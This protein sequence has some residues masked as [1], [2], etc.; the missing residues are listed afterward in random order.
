VRVFDAGGDKPLPGLSRLE[1]PN[2]A[3]GVRG[4]RALRENPSILEAQLESIA[5]AAAYTDADVWVMAPMVSEPE[6]AQ[7]FAHMVAA[8][9]LRT[10]GVMIEVPAAALLAREILSTVD[11]ASIGTNDLTAV[12]ARGRPSARGDGPLAGPVAPAVLRLVSEVGRAAGALGKPLGVC[13]EA[14][15]DPRLACV[16]VGLGVTSLSMAPAA[17]ACV[18]EELALHTLDECRRMAEEALGI[19]LPRIDPMRQTQV[20][21]AGGGPAGLMLGL[22]L[23]RQGIE[24]IVLEK[25]ADF[26][27]DFRGDTV[28]S[29]TLNILDEIGLT[30]VVSKLPGRRRHS[31]A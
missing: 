25:H 26:L 2:P 18:R 15:G 6:E 12:H 30:D 3:L 29:S 20:C 4:I 10:A 5:E 17:L 23:A 7:W 19:P 21:V 13:G 24:T 11:F 1:E 27:R 9:R 14:A 31:C 16:L 22:L 28:H 8:H